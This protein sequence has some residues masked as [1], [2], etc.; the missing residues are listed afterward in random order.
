MVEEI[1]KDNWRECEDIQKWIDDRMKTIEPDDEYLE[2]YQDKYGNLDEE[3]K[4]GV[5]KS[6]HEADNWTREQWE[7]F[8]DLVIDAA[9]IDFENSGKNF[10]EEELKELEKG[11]DGDINDDLFT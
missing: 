5:L 2:W 11:L 1:N 10:T 8:F 3:G 4:E 9:S 6:K 7:E